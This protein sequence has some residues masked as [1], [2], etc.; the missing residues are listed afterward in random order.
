MVLKKEGSEWV[1]YSHKTHRHLGTFRTKKAAL[2]R[3]SQI[4]FF[5][6]KSKAVS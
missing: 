6:N 5:K 2:K 3:K 1:L 4:R